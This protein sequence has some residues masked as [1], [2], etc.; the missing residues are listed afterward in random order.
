MTAWKTSQRRPRQSRVRDPHG[1]FLCHLPYCDDFF[2]TRHDGLHGALSGPVDPHE[3]RRMLQCWDL[4]QIS[5][6]STGG[7]FPRHADKHKV[8]MDYL[9]S[10][11]S[12]IHFR[13]AEADRSGATLLRVF[14]V[15]LQ[16]CRTPALADQEE[17]HRWLHCGL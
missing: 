12:Y 14:W 13:F 1:A 15:R 2:A 8:C 5:F 10:T 7:R 11:S 3:H 4:A 17:S 16:R 6:I 9:I